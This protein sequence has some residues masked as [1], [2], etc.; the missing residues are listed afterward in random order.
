[1][2]AAGAP[3]VPTE[4]R[5]PFCVDVAV[6]RHN[7]GCRPVRCPP[8]PCLVGQDITGADFLVCAAPESWQ[9]LQTLEKVS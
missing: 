9:V 1:M 2:T 6:W 3:Y 5:P 8:S 7:F 4:A